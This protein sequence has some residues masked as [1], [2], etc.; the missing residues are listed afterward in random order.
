MLIPA[1]KSELKAMPPCWLA[2]PAQAPTPARRPAVRSRMVER[3]SRPANHD[4]AAQG[5]DHEVLQAPVGFLGPD[6]DDLAG[7]DEGDQQGQ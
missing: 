6:G 7:C 1:A 4:R 5:T 3:P 2:A